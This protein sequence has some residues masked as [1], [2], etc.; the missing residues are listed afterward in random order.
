MS[1]A[2]YLSL[3]I[4]TSLLATF[5][6]STCQAAPILLAEFKHDT[7]GLELELGNVPA[8]VPF[9]FEAYY[10]SGG[11]DFLSWED[12]Y[13]P[14]DVGMT[15]VAPQEIVDLATLTIAMPVFTFSLKTGPA[16]FSDPMSFTFGT[17]GPGT[18]IQR[19]VPDLSQYTVTRVER[20]IDKLQLN[21]AQGPF[22]HLSGAQTVRYWGVPVPEPFAAPLLLIGVA[23]LLLNHRPRPRS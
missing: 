1:N 4:A 14:M 7:I 23:P 12:D 8:T 5:M 10:T 21:D 16:N 6:S 17:C 2:R 9:D 15:F 11:T 19:F 13:G 22:Y 18:C 20:I 3:T